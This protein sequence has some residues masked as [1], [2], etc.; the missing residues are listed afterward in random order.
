MVYSSLYKV[1]QLG[2]ELLYELH[3]YSLK[4]FLIVL[5]GVLYIIIK[6][7]YMHIATGI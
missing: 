3:S 1:L 2:T 6:G 4:K 5:Y 7:I